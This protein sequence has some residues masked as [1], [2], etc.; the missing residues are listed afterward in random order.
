M[1]KKSENPLISWPAEMSIKNFS[2]QWFLVHTKSRNEK[3]L[4]WDLVS[5]EINYFLPMCWKTSH[6]KGR[7]FKSLLPLFTG[8]MFFN[9]NEN[10]RVKVLR[11]N[12]VAN[13]IEV[14]DQQQ[15]IKE[16]SE[17]EQA[18]KAGA[19]LKPDKYIKAGQL[20]QVTAGPLIGLKGI[21][22]VTTSGAR[23]MLNIDMLGQAASVEIDSDIIELVEE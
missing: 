3:A 2:D 15:L 16:L 22:Q 19:D 17:I 23:L 7:K 11:T 8:Y 18:L 21:A 5:K 4:A 10:Q 6:S 14:R 20:C 13:I 9:G 12:R 1:L